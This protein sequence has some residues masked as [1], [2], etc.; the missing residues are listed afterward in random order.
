MMPLGISS[1]SDEGQ[2]LKPV[3]R[4]PLCFRKAYVAKQ[5][6]I[7]GT[8]ETHACI[9]RRTK[10]LRPVLSAACLPRV[11]QGCIK[12]CSSIA[13]IAC[14]A[15]GCEPEVIAYGHHPL[16][17]IAHPDTRPW[18]HSAPRRIPG[19]PVS[20]GGFGQGAP[21]VGGTCQRSDQG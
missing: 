13:T 20:G 3:Q 10:W 5:A 6:I 12:I 15:R 14:R 16:A 21:Q 17:V 19:A 2:I 1:A 11:A 18:T 4:L 8:R 9:E 7:K